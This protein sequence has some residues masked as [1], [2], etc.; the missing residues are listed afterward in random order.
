MQRRLLL[1]ASAPSGP[2][3]AI[4]IAIRYRHAGS[5][6]LRFY[7]NSVADRRP[8]TTDH[9]PPTAGQ[10]LS[11]SWLGGG[12]HKVRPYVLWLHPRFSV[13]GSRFSV[14]GSRFSVL[15]GCVAANTRFA[16][17]F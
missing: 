15:R 9:R 13:L 1:H 6:S 8:P 2:A 5:V 17:T 12:E 10:V 16:L 11:S 3:A 4:I 14:L 7:F